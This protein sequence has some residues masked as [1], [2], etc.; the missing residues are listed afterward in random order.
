MLHGLKRH[1]YVV[2]FLGILSPYLSAPAQAQ[3]QA[4]TQTDAAAAAGESVQAA[5]STEA[6]EADEAADAADA[7]N[8]ALINAAS[9]LGDGSAVLSNDLTFSLRLVHSVKFPLTTDRCYYQ[10]FV[11][12]QGSDALSDVR[13]DLDLALDGRILGSTSVVV[14][15][16]DGGMLSK[17]IRQFAFDGPCQMDGVRVTA[18]TGGF[19]PLGAEYSLPVDLFERGGVSTADFEPLEIALGG[20]ARLPGAPVIKDERDTVNGNLERVCIKQVSNLRTGPGTE[21]NI[22]TVLQPGTESFI[23][24]RTG[25]GTWNQIRTR[26]G[27]RGWVYF[28]LVWGC[29]N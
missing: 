24:R 8:A 15:D 21:Y 20:T 22:V 7:L 18:A 26:T 9:A 13:F 6:A 16:L 12:A 27:Q 4:Q 10:F 2:V 23:E 28:T 19:T 3:A 17:R 5:D 25:D 1:L 14:S 29:P 11:D